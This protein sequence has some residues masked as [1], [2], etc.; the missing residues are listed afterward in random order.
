MEALLE[1]VMKVDMLLEEEMAEAL[2]EVQME[3]LVYALVGVR[4]SVQRRGQELA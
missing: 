3:A 2:V 4:F 1:E